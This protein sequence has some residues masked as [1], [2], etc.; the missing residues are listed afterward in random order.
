[1]NAER[2]A[3]ERA[4]S[5]ADRLDDLIEQLDEISFD[6]LRETAADGRSD[7]PAFDRT[8]VQARR[9]VARASGLLRGRPSDD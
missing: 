2:R 4:E 6:L 8:L 1:M 9:A 3:A 5:I 7:R